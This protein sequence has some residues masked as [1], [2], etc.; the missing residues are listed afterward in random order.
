MHIGT[1]ALFGVIFALLV[2]LAVMP[3]RGDIFIL[4]DSDEVIMSGKIIDLGFDEFTLEH[5]GREIDITVDQMEIDTFNTLN[6]LLEEGMQVTVYGFLEDGGDRVEA[7][8][9]TSMR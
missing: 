3:A 6:P 4:E 7:T 8:R 5:N 9:I 2:L 1:K